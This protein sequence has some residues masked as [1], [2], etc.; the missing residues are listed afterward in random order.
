MKTEL[1]VYEPVDQSLNFY[2]LL[3]QIADFLV[4]FYPENL[5]QLFQF[6]ICN[7]KSDI[8]TIY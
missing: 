5:V 1:I 3:V 2:G 4:I 7:Q 6:Y 8:D